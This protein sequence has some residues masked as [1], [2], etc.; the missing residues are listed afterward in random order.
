[1]K[2]RRSM[3]KPIG[4]LFLLFEREEVNEEQEKPVERRGCERS[5][6]NGIRVLNENGKDEEDENKKK[7]TKGSKEKT[8]R[9]PGLVRRSIRW[10]SY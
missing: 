9:G 10:L 6:P 5:N 3:M 1:M 2:K 4:L 8:E 7:Q